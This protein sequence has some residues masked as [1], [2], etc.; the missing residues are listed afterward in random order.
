[1]TTDVMVGRPA[2]Y[3]SWFTGYEA[4]ARVAARNPRISTRWRASSGLVAFVAPRNMDASYFFDVVS[5]PG[6]GREVGAGVV[7]GDFERGRQARPS[8]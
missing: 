6:S 3:L 7:G 4:G 8:R 2:L 5:R 1:M